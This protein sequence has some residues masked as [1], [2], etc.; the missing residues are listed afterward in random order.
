M[1]RSTPRT[2]GPLRKIVFAD[3]LEGYFNVWYEGL[4]CGHIHMV[5]LSQ[6]PTTVSNRRRCR[7]C[8]WE[9]EGRPPQDT[10]RARRRITQ[11]QEHTERNAD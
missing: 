10:R 11:A 7:D 8:A 3:R 1:P 9:K 4:S 5:R 6:E 2:L